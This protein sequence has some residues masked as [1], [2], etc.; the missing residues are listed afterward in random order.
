MT[1]ALNSENYTALSDDV[2]K[3][4]IA[5]AVIGACSVLKATIPEVEKGAHVC[6]NFVEI[7]GGTIVAEYMNGNVTLSR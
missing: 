6:A 7:N 4:V 2:T 5:G 1:F 3:K